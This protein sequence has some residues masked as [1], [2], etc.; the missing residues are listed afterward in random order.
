MKLAQLILEGIT[1][2]NPN[3]S[4]EW[5]EAIRYPEFEEMG[6]QG[7]IDIAKKGYITS[8]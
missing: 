4:T 2:S 3:F 7:W 1:Y 5:E 6:K 8:F